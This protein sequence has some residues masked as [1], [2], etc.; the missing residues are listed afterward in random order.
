MKELHLINIHVITSVIATFSLIPIFA[1]KK[2]SREHLIFGFIYSL[3][4]FLTAFVILFSYG[5]FF[6]SHF[7]FAQ[8][9]FSTGRLSGLT[10]LILFCAQLLNGVIFVQ[11]LK[12]LERFRSVRSF[13]VINVL[14]IIAALLI[15]YD[16]Y[17]H[18][19]TLSVAFCGVILFNHVLLFIFG[20]CI[21]ELLRK[22]PED[23]KEG[24]NAIHASQIVSSSIL[25]IFIGMGATLGQL[26][27][28]LEADI[29]FNMKTTLVFPVSSALMLM[30]F[31]RYR[32]DFKKGGLVSQTAK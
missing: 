23:L 19:S 18:G 28:G 17:I 4:S 27:F 15:L 2:G 32:F 20:I 12:W 16:L 11:K 3:F 24:M 9:K 29:K 13:I 30:W 6:T 14:T 8:F 7:T 25:F 22:N 26:I 21:F 5:N 10:E 31:F 1:C